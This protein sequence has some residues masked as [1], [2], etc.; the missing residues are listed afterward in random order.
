MKSGVD[1]KKKIFSRRKAIAGM[2]AGGAGL[3]LASFIGNGT[4]GAHPG[5]ENMTTGQ[6]TTNAFMQNVNWEE[7]NR[8]AEA[9][10]KTSAT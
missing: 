2:A 3:A 8:R 9:A 6:T 5:S 1:M 7:V 10:L 4:A